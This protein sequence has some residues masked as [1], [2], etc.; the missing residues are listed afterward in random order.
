MNLVFQNILSVEGKHDEH[1]ETI[2]K[3]NLT[4]TVLLSLKVKN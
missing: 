2:R 3:N 4:F 1:H